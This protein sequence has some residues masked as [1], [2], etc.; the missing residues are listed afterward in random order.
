MR[1]IALLIIHMSVIGSAW[2]LSS[3]A[4][5]VP[6]SPAAETPRITVLDDAFGTLLAQSDAL[7]EGGPEIM[8]LA[9]TK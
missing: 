7:D 9:Q 5:T 1:Q 6:T 2:L 8:S 3:C 4:T